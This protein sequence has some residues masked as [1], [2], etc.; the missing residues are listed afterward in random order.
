MKTIRIETDKITDWETFHDV[1]AEA[2]GFPD[3]YGRNMNAW[4]DCMSDVST[5]GREGMTSFRI[6]L[7][8]K[9]VLDIPEAEAWKKRCPEVFEAF[10]ECVAFANCRNLEADEQ[11]ELLLLLH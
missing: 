2:F 1:F 7:G 5:T 3:F 9:L 6:E 11:C 8:D 10:V 4:I